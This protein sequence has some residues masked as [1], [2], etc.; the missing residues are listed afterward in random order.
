MVKCHDFLS[1]LSL[2]NT[3]T[4]WMSTGMFP[5]EFIIHFPEPTNIGTV[6]VD[7]YNG[8]EAVCTLGQTYMSSSKN[9]G[10]MCKI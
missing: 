5:Q 8:M 10:S 1:F 3:K 2:R 9:V 7:S 6:T 4:F